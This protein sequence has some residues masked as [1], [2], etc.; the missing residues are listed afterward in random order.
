MKPREVTKY[1]QVQYDAAIVERTRNGPTMEITRLLSDLKIRLSEEYRM[2]Q[3]ETWNNIIT[4]LDIEE[5]STKF[6]KTV[7]RHKGNNK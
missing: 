3:N 4:K 2:L 5:N 7:R 1:I 6:W